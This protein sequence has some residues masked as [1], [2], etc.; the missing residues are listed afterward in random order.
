MSTTL[1]SWARVRTPYLLRFMAVGAIAGSAALGLACGSDSS[2]DNGGGSSSGSTPTNA[3]GAAARQF[4]IDKVYPS[5]EPTCAKCHASG[6]KG[7]PV[8]LASGGAASY[9]AI[10]GV[11]GLIADPSQSPIVQHGL[12]SGPALTSDQGDL[13]TQWLKMEVVARKLSGD[14]G[15]PANLRAAFK[16]FG[17]CMDYNEWKQLG[18]DQLPQRDTED[19][20]QCKSCHLAGQASLWLNDDPVET[21][22]KFTQFPYVQRLVTGSVN[23]SGAFDTLQASWRL[24][25]KGQE[26]QQSNANS[27]PRFQT[28]PALHTALQQFVSDT[29]SNMNAGRCQNVVQP[30]DGGLEAG[31]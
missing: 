16:A 20:G 26:A 30:G 31:K 22:M 23:P 25:D 18:L 19:S 10:D 3:D 9:T 17:A 12:H 8:W 11:A 6:D 13:V 27:H 15:R 2:G 14:T 4:F 29:I 5:I 21:F 24:Q 28:A 7:A 1:T